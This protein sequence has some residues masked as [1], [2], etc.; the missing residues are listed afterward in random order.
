MRIAQEFHRSAMA[1]VQ[2]RLRQCLEGQAMSMESLERLSNA[3]H[4]AT[5]GDEAAADATVDTPDGGIGMMMTDNDDDRDGND[6]DFGPAAT[7]NTTGGTALSSNGRRR[8]VAAGKLRGE[9][10]ALGTGAAIHKKQRIRT[11][12]GR[13]KLVAHAKQEQDAGGKRRPRYFVQF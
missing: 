9:N 1:K 4:P 5:A 10:R 7:A 2:G 12:H 6:E 3:L 11:K 8:P 13:P